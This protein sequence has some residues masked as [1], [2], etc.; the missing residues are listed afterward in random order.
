MLNINADVAAR[1]LAI[2]ITPQRVVYTSSKGGWIDDVSDGKKSKQKREL[3]IEQR[4]LVKS[5]PLL[6]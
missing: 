1:E 2:A 5:F 4:T 3:T 6:T